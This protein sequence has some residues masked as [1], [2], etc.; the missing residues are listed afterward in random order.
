MNFGFYKI[1]KVLGLLNN[2]QLLKEGPVTW[3]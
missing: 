1:K 2:C 3:S